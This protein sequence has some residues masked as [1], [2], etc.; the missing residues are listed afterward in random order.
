MNI[1]AGD[2]RGVLQIGFVAAD[3][4]TRRGCCNSVVLHVLV[5]VLVLLRVDSLGILHSGFVASI[6][7]RRRNNLDRN[8]LLSVLAKGMRNDLVRNLLLNFDG[9]EGGSCNGNL[10]AELIHMQPL[11]LSLSVP[12]SNFQKSATDYNEKQRTLTPATRPCP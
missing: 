9:L 11:L 4:V 7:A 2:L 1:M 6:S 8:L 10:V 3:N 5:L 12:A